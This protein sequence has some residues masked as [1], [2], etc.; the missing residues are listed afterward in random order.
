M[1]ALGFRSFLD[2]SIQA[3]IIY[4]FHAPADAGVRVQALLLPRCATAASSSTRASS[5]SSRRSAVGCI[6]AIGPSDMR[7]AVL[8]IG[9]AMHA[10]G[11]RKMAPAIARAA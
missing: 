1:K 3:P 6:G 9:D 7:A 2:A 4:T 8:A 5:R 11:I 10:M